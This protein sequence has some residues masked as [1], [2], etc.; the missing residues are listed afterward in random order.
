LCPPLH[1]LG[2]TPNLITTVGTV[3]TCYALWS[4]YHGRILRFLA[5]YALG[6]VLDCLDGHFA[7]RYHLETDW[8]DW[9][10]HGRD[11]V[12]L[13]ATVAVMVHRYVGR[14][15]PCL[16]GLALLVILSYSV[17]LVMYTGCLDR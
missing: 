7:R 17:L 8:G 10:D 9:Y 4:L 3:S 16:L 6:Y 15:A 11:W 5:F 13:V 14:V 1:A 2:F 12:L